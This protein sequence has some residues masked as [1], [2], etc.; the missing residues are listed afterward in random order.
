MSLISGSNGPPPAVG[1]GKPVLFVRDLP[2]RSR[3]CKGLTPCFDYIEAR[4]TGTTVGESDCPAHY[5]CVEM[6]EICRVVRAF[7]PNFA[8]VHVDAAFVDSLGVIKALLNMDMLTGM[9]REL[10]LYLAAAAH[11]PALNTASVDDFTDSLLTWWRTNGKSFPAWAVAA[12]IAFAISPNSASCERVF[13]LLKLMYG[14]QQM[15]TL[16]DALEASLMLR[17]NGRRIG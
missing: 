10:H 17:F 1:D 16:S 14:E 13:A 8:H 15:L 7:N 5:S 3:I 4:L 11:A 9:K 6:Y 2:E 12:R